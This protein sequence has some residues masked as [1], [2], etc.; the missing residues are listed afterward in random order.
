MNDL[1]NQIYNFKNLKNR[2]FALRHGQSV[3][4]VE[5]Y[6]A[7]SIQTQ[8]KA[9][10]TKVGVNQ[11]QKSVSEISDILTDEVV[12]I[13]SDFIRAHETASVAAETLGLSPENIQIDKRLRE[14]FF[15][16]Y[17][18]KSDLYYSHVWEVHPDSTENDIESV[19]SV[20]FRTTEIIRDLENEFSN[21]IFLLVSHGDPLMILNTGFKKLKMELFRSFGEFENAEIKE[22]CL[23]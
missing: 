6:I 14:R 12:I 9:G 19:N 13:S 8:T 10:L 16:L 20:L 5:K 1:H 21:K 4:N 11:V 3:A 18:G 23:S 7:S 17:D 15:G 2:Y 22:L